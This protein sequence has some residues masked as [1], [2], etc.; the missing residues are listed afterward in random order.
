M[1]IMAVTHLATAAIMPPRFSHGGIYRQKHLEQWKSGFVAV[2][3]R[4]ARH[5]LI[6]L[7]LVFTPF[8]V[9]AE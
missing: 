7:F 5:E 8:C 3:A 1:F 6:E 2:V 9:E 4:F